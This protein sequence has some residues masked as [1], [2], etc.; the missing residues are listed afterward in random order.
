MALG[1]LVL[2]FSLQKITRRVDN[3]NLNIQKNDT[4]KKIPDDLKPMKVGQRINERY[5]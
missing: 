4:W 1:Q 3:V 5:H 2:Q